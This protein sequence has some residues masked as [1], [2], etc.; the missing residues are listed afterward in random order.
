MSFIAGLEQIAYQPAASG[1]Y[2]EANTVHILRRTGMLYCGWES[3]SNLERT[4]A[5]ALQAA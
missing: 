3:K 2:Q 5:S 4:R 1:T